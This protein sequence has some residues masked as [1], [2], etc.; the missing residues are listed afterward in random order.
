MA[1]TN[2]KAKKFKLSDGTRIS[3]LELAKQLGCSASVARSRLKV[4]KD[5][6]YLFRPVRQR[7][8]KSEYGLYKT[9][10]LDDGREMTPTQ[11]SKISGVNAL[12]VM[13]R[14]RRG[15]TDFDKLTE[16]VKKPEFM[17]EKGWTMTNELKKHIH[18][19]NCFCPMSRL[20]LRTV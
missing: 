17:P 3:A 8:N 18:E 10:T 16:E 5:P 1:A 4:S 2:R 9:I 13:G 11:L 12:T 15:I 7:F 20:V 6:E 19:R 14:V